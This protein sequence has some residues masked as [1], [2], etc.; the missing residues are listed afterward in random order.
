MLSESHAIVIGEFLTN[1]I[2]LGNIAF[3][4]GYNKVTEL[5]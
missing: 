4:A 5:S 2:N 3:F 1:T